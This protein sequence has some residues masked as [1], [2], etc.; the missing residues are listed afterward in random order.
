M[1]P[2]VR[3]K[4]AQDSVN[5]LGALRG[6]ASTIAHARVR[7]ETIETIRSAWPMGWLD[8]APMLEVDDA[9]C[10][11]LGSRAYEAHCRAAIAKAFQWPLLAPL[12]RTT[13]RLFEGSRT[14]PLRMLPDAFGLVFRDCGEMKS[15]VRPSDTVI[16]LTLA[17]PIIVA[18]PAFRLG[19]QAAIGA[20]LETIAFRHSITIEA[21]AD[22]LTFVVKY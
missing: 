15:S 6:T 19:I 7:A 2:R 10:V 9:I 22:R 3:A 11:A 12:L 4:W 8:V 16:T 18:S 20:T 14:A 1:E 21:G 5:S 17:P 13:L